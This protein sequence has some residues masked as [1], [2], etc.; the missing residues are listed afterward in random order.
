MTAYMKITI[1]FIFGALFGFAVAIGTGWL[2]TIKGD[3]P[4]VSPK[5]YGDIA[6]APLRPTQKDLSGKELYQSLLLTKDDEIFIRINQDKSGNTRELFVSNNKG[7]PILYVGFTDNK[8][9]VL[10]YGRSS[11]H[12]C[13]I[14]FD[15]DG[16]FD[17]MISVDDNGEVKAEAAYFKETQEWE[18][19]CESNK[20][21]D[22]IKI[23]D[24]TYIFIPCEGWQEVDQ[25]EL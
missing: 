11:L 14:D 9:A 5:L 17:Y 23:E 10:K 25:A 21:K 12:Q 6:I 18:S 2:I 19:V 24:K 16:E 22:R 8:E 3:A 20:D 13:F 4:L 1:S 7:L 15:T